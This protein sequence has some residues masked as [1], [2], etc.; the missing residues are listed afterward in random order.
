MLS[1]NRQTEIYDGKRL[2]DR[3]EYESRFSDRYM[4][5]NLQVCD[6]MLRTDNISDYAGNILLTHSEG[7][8][9]QNSM[10]TPVR[11]KP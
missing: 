3:R 6:E 11:L 10:I 4:D 9:E 7:L 8:H 2:S 5:Q 1:L